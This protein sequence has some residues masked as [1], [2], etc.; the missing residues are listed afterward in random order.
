MPILGSL[1]R[2]IFL[3]FYLLAWLLLAFYLTTSKLGPETGVEYRLP[4]VSIAS[5]DFDAARAGQPLLD[6]EG[7]LLVDPTRDTVCFAEITAEGLIM[8]SG[9]DVL[10]VKGC[11]RATRARESGSAYVLIQVDRAARYKDLV[12]L[13]DQLQWFEQRG[14]CSM[15]PLVV[16]GKV[17]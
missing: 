16:H 8:F 12:R 11:C 10:G 17:N 3:V 9:P 4:P 6:A 15:L 2:I 14:W 1:S 5:G 7:K 13:L